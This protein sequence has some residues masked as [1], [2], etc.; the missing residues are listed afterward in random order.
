M[1]T[2]ILILASKGEKVVKTV[3]AGVTRDSLTYE[4]IVSMLNGA[5]L[6]VQNKD[7]FFKSLNKLTI[8]IKST[9]T[10]IKQNNDKK[11]VNNEYI[12]LYIYYDKSV[13]NVFTS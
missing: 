4:Q 13:K 8:Q 10:T 12:P 3:F 1:V 5:E 6:T 7:R 2:G 9:Q 11:L